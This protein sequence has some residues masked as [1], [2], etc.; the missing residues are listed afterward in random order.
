MRRIPRNPAQAARPRGAPAHLCRRNEEAAHLLNVFRDL[1]RPYEQGSV[2]VPL[3]RRVDF[4]KTIAL[5]RVHVRQGHPREEHASRP[6][7][8]GNPGQVGS[9]RGD[10]VHF[11]PLSAAGD[12]PDHVFK[13]H[14]HR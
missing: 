2:R 4:A 12:R 3:V 9:S 10:Q 6:R 11:Q 7:T 14:A 8:L 13:S 5:A 1:V